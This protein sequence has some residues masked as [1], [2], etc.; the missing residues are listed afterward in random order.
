MFRL[1]GVAKT[2]KSVFSEKV[3][4]NIDFG[5]QIWCVLEVFGLTWATLGPTFAH[6]FAQLCSNTVLMKIGAPGH[7]RMEVGG[8]GA[9]A[10]ALWESETLAP[11]EWFSCEEWR[12]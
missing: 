11:W 3:S 6:V 8:V 5:S 7:P 4:K 2:R 12:H 9:E 10:S 1:R